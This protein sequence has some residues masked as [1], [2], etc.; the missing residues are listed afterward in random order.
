MLTPAQLSDLAFRFDERLAVDPDEL[1]IDLLPGSSQP[2]ERSQAAALMLEIAAA[3]HDYDLGWLHQCWTSSGLD[4]RPEDL[5]ASL[6]NLFE[7]RVEM[8]HGVAWSDIEVF[9]FPAEDL[10]LSRPIDRAFL[11]QVLF[12]TWR[13][14][15]RVASGGVAVVYRGVSLTDGSVAAVKIPRRGTDDKSDSEYADRIRE[16]AAILKQVAGDGV[17]RRLDFQEAEFGP[18]LVIDW[19]DTEGGPGLP[20]HLDQG[21]QLRLIVQT[22]RSLDRLH[23]QD[24]I[25]GDVKLENIL[26]DRQQRVWLTDFNISR[27]APPDQNTDGPLPGT[28]GMM[29]Q[30]SLVGVAADAGVSQDIYALGVLLYELIAS[31]PFVRAASREEALVASILMGDVHEPEFP[32]E[33]S[34][35]LKTICGTATTRHVDRRFATAVDFADTL[36]H[37]LEATLAKEMIPPPRRRLIAWQFGTSL[38]LCLTRLR[39]MQEAFAATRELDP[40]DKLP[41]PVRDRIGYGMGVAL[42][43]EDAQSA[44]ERLSWEL[45]SP[46]DIE[47]LRTAAYRAPH[48]R[49][50]DLPALEESL[51]A[52][53]VWFRTLWRG[54]EQRIT[55]EQPREALMATVAL[56]SRF[57]PRSKTARATWRL[58]AEQTGLPEVIRASFAGRF[59]DLQEA[60]EWRSALMRLDYDVGKWLR[61]DEPA[62]DVLP[63][64]S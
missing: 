2:V 26:V 19:I 4:V 15:E 23:R 30:E 51:D 45:P 61:Y 11:G 31:R 14:E 12:G 8:R 21:S 41:R 59:D 49:A 18:V 1:P 3:C 29:S 5:I 52:V 63:S 47:G 42:A 27:A 39:T 60:E 32:D 24:L 64:R 46:P 36:E 48:L 20:P 56:Q 38:G 6:R 13:L 40:S 9:G 55:P 53:E 7:S 17:P 16:E 10:E 22:A 28:L 58:L 50:S 54:I 34:E 37:Y 35:L 44:V 57:A 62:D 33:T 25:H 43:A